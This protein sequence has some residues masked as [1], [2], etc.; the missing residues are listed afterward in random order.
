VL[1]PVV[2]AAMDDSD[3]TRVVRR[4]GYTGGARGRNAMREYGAWLGKR[5]GRRLWGRV[6]SNGMAA[7]VAVMLA[8]AAEDDDDGGG[9]ED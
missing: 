4:L 7:M 2:R 3:Y 6:V 1:V 8:R 5:H 9:D